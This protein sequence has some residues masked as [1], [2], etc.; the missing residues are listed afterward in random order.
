[1]QQI[2]RRHH[3]LDENRRRST[4]FFEKVIDLADFMDSTVTQLEDD[5]QNCDPRQ[6]KKILSKHNETERAIEKHEKLKDEVVKEG[7]AML[8]AA[9]LPSDKPVLEKELKCVQQNWS[10]LQ[11]TSWN[12]SRDIQESMVSSGRLIDA[13]ETL[14]EWLIRVE[15]ELSERRPVE[16]DLD[17]VEKLIDQHREFKRDLEEREKSFA[18]LR[19]LASDLSAQD[20]AWMRPQISGL[21]TRWEELRTLSRK[22]DDKLARAKARAQEF[23]VIFSLLN[24][25][26]TPITAYLAETVNTWLNWFKNILIILNRFY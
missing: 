25:L 3:I 2:N 7:N 12:Y 4:N 15:P 24:L 17:T 9:K 26:S 13:L 16:G 21:G 10:H 22:R 8:K 14:E 6:G 20:S 23:Q 18:H 5:K 1:M 19:R 11:T